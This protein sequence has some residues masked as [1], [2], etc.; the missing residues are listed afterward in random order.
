MKSHT[1]RYTNMP[2]LKNKVVLI[3]GASSG[4]GE[5][6]AWFFAAEG[7]RLVLAAR[8]I[9][10]LQILASRIQDEG[11]E[12][13]A[14]PM[15]IVNPADVENMVQSA[16]DLYGQI[17]ILF[18]NAGI[19]RVGWFEEH[20][21]E[22]DIDL[23]IQ[24]NLIGMMR[25]T[26]MALPH[27]IERRE[28]HIINMLSVAGLISPPLI[29]SYSASKFGAR[30]FTDALRREV[31]PFGIKVSGIYP[32]PAATE[33]GQHI[34]RNKAY[35]SFRSKINLRM[36]SEYVAKRVVDVAKRPRRSLVIP[37]WFR[38]VTTFDT[39]FPVAVDWITYIFSKFKHK[40]D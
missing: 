10:R 39:L 9:D 37:W 27:M 11:G 12:A 7:C 23:L 28:G 8:R 32:G 22:R 4:F 35:R 17:D 34:G 1:Q 6:T 3:T 40:L 20:S 5:D 19:G 15:D 33:F 31:A 13:F 2:T 25:V 30:A 21:M 24:V 26:R 36:S 29:T 18:N 14:V 16:L 38:I